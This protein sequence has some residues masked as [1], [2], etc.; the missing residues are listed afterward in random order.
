MDGKTYSLEFTVTMCLGY[1][2]GGDVCVTVDVTE[3]EY[4]LL[5]QCCRDE[6]DIYDC[7]ELEDLCSRIEAEARSENDFIMSGLGDDEEMDYD[8]ISYMIDIPDEIYES[9]EEEEEDL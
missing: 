4:E 5:K 3:K 7:G 8:S 2:D 9:V 1:G 6:I